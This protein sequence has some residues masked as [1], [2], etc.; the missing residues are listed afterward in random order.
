MFYDRTRIFSEHFRFSS[1]Q[2]N[3]IAVT[4]SASVS[5]CAVR[6]SIYCSAIICVAR[7]TFEFHL[8]DTSSMKWREGLFDTT[9]IQWSNMEIQHS[10]VISNWMAEEGKYPNCPFVITALCLFLSSWQYLMVISHPHQLS[11]AIE[12]V[13]YIQLHFFLLCFLIFCWVVHRSYSCPWNHV[14][15]AFFAFYVVVQ[16]SLFLL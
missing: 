11:F 5:C 1:V 8:S 16:L 4:T 12:R 7:S 3:S 13:F 15:F 6:V 10:S 2:K 9:R 14:A